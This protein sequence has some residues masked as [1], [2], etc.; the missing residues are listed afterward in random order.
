MTT[1]ELRILDVDKMRNMI[2]IKPRINPLHE[3]FT[4]SWETVFSKFNIK[5]R[6]Y[7]CK[8]GNNILYINKEF[9][10]RIS[11][12]YIKHEN[13]D[14]DDEIH[15]DVPTKKMD[16]HIAMKAVKYDISPYIYFMG[17]IHWN[18]RI[19][20]YTIIESY[21]MTLSYFFYKKK[22]EELMENSDYYQTIDELYDDISSQ[23]VHIVDT[24]TK[25]GYIYYDFKPDNIVLNIKEGRVI[26]KVIDWDSEFCIC[27]PWMF[28]DD[29]ETQQYIHDGIRFINILLISFCLYCKH[30]NNILNKTIINLFSQTTFDYM[31]H[32]FIE[33]ENLYI[34]MI[35]H[36]YYDM[37][38]MTLQ[39]KDD[40]FHID[41]TQQN[42]QIFYIMIHMIKMSFKRNEQDTMDIPYIKYTQ[43]Q[44]SLIM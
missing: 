2:Q 40:F 7:Y 38:N 20:R 1:N 37:F 27:E 5:N 28:K 23:L 25:M 35:I 39:Q 10:L 12:R 34:Q 36:Y 17:N 30:N 8:G 6:N 3:S 4:D 42:K 13:E 16:E 33:T 31:Y 32:I 29:V 14:F 26:L 15:L 41:H 22:Y 44:N 9:T 21:E 11:K 19:H 43:Y 24:I 18:S